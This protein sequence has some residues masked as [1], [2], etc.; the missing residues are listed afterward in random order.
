MKPQPQQLSLFPR[1][2]LT[3]RLVLKP[4]P[5][6]I[7]CCKQCGKQIA[8]YDREHHH[9]VVEGVCAECEER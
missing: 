7:V 2:T 4:S 8:Q 6:L 9:V 5:A 1:P 3:Q